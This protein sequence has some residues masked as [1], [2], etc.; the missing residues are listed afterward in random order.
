MR[1]QRAIAAFRL[2]SIRR[3]KKELFED[4]DEYDLGHLAHNPFPTGP[5]PVHVELV[6]EQNKIGIL[7]LC[8]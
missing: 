3:G 5:N 8:D 2:S 1:S 6:I 7:R 4:E